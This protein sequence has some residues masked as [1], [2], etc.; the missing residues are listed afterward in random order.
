MR[1]PIPVKKKGSKQASKQASPDA[2]KE[3]GPCT[4]GSRG[5]A[6]A[7]R[8]SP[9]RAS[10]SSDSQRTQEPSPAPLPEALCQEQ[11]PCQESSQRTLPEPCQ[12]HLVLKSNLIKSNLPTHPA[13]S[14]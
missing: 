12:E 2:S 8:P 14:I 7:E 13:T 10:R 4:A 1:V 11:E 5:L 9:P 3:R 6:F